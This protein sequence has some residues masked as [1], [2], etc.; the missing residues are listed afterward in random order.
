MEIQHKGF[1]KIVL[2]LVIVFLI[3]GY[4]GFNL[5]TIVDSPTV[6]SNLEYAIDAVLHLWNIFIVGPATYIWNKV[7]VAMLIEPLIHFGSKATHPTI[8]TSAI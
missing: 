7:I 4:F 2:L 5:K 1:I 8:D 6:H 3:L